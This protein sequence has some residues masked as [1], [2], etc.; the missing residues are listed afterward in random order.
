M[1]ERK[2]IEENRTRTSSNHKI[3]EK[4]TPSKRPIKSSIKS[5]NS[6]KGSS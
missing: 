4:S 3:D 1:N 2:I 5:L 6:K